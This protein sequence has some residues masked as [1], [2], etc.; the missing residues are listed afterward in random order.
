MARLKAGR[1]DGELYAPT[2]LFTLGSEGGVKKTRASPGSHSL[3][4]QSPPSRK[5][6]VQTFNV[7]TF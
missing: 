4:I 6:N 2:V 3:T 1:P 7:P 5:G